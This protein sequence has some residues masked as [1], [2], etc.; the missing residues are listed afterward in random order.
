MRSV[1]R[2]FSSIIAALLL[3]SAC[4]CS[5]EK[6]IQKILG[7]STDSPVFLGCRSVSRDEVEF[8][9]SCSVTV[10]SLRFDPPL[11]TVSVGSG[12]QVIVRISETLPEGSRVTADVLVE[13]EHG[14][15]LQ[16][17]VP[18]RTRNDRIP[19][20]LI[21]ELRTEYSKP[22]VEF[23]EIKTAAAGNM[24]AVR[25]YTASQGFET[26]VYEFP[27]VE[28]AADE[29][30]VLHL[31]TLDPES[32][33]ET[34]TDLALSPGNEASPNARD[35]WT[36]GAVKRLRKTDAVFFLDQ[37]DRIIDAVLLSETADAWWAKEEMVSAA[38]MF[39]DHG[40]WIPLDNPE[41]TLVSP[42]DAVITQGATA[43]RTVC[44]DETLPDRN[45]AA[46]WYICATSQ[47]TPGGT[48]SVKRYTP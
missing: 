15:T 16:V 12:E 35:F 26:P 5:P 31:R 43:T 17:L 29:Y 9:F 8:R 19:E 34:G 25:V 33:D 23:I 18:F 30:I 27:P 40:A 37:D 41:S 44:R 45:N 4:A 11:E 1:L 32:A 48:N 6:S 46:D 20:F 22:R 39:A 28:V 14:N 13:D 2:F 47:A 36:P 3:F 10:A 21:N 42:R 24:G 38:Q 7:G